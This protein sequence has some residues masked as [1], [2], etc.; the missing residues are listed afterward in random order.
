MRLIV[1][2]IISFI[3]GSLFGFIIAAIL[4]ASEESE[5]IVD[6]PSHYQGKVECIDLMR[7]NFGDEAVKWFCICNAF[8]YRFRAGQK[9]G[10]T[11]EEDIAKATW[12]ENYVK[13]KLSNK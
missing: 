1:S 8:K 5:N 3:V 4:A 10:S 12:Y 13:N 6:H 11:Y 7:S 2:Y 9:Q